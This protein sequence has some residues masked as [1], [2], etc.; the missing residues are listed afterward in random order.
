MSANFRFITHAAQG[1]PTV[2]T[3]RRSRNA[4]TEGRFTDAGRPDEEQNGTFFVLSE[5]ADR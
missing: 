3:S 4:S 1:N 5:L 2:F